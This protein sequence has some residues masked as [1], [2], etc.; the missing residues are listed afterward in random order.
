MKLSLLLLASVSLAGTGISE[1]ERVKSKMDG[2][3]SKWRVRKTGRFARV[4]GP[5]IQNW[6]VHR[7]KTERSEQ[8]NF[9]RFQGIKIDG[10]KGRSL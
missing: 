2:L 3:G 6:T 1:R 8:M 10:P 7:K 9:G 5:E 4:D